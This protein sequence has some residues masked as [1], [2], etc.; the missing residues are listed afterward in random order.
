MRAILFGLTGYGNA[1]F[2]AL[3]AC[4]VDVPLVVTRREPGS[5]PYYPCEQ[6]S[7]V[8]AAAGSTVLCDVDPD[9]DDAAFAKIAEVD[10]DVLVVASYDKRL[11][12]HVAKLAKR[13]INIHPSLLPKYR[14]PTPS[15]WAIIFDEKKT[16]VTLHKLA[17]H[18]D[19]GDILIQ[20]ELDLRKDE[21]D[22]ELRAR[23]AVLVG[24]V[25]TE[26]IAGVAAGREPEASAQDESE[27]TV[28]PAVQRR[29]AHVRFDQGT[30]T[31][32]RRIRGVTP[33][34]GAY[35]DFCG[36]EFDIAYVKAEGFVAY[37][38]RTLQ[39]HRQRVDLR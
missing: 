13:A 18:L 36:A 6:L 8:A 10:A 14:G 1:A 29:D 37:D 34:P 9:R 38:D 4:G 35:T 12:T 3:R 11:S 30:Q 24:E 22:G 26:Y 23:L 33:Y 19:G 7:D 39:C 16:G 27:I 31:I 5:Y 15:N 21:T 32:L 25:L 17:R 28:Y 2:D 20:H